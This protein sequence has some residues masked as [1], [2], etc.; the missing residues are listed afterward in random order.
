MFFFLNTSLH[1]LRQYHTYDSIISL[2]RFYIM[3]TK[4]SS[5][6]EHTRGSAIGV[7]IRYI[8]KPRFFR[9]RNIDFKV[10]AHKTSYF[11]IAFEGL[12]VGEIEKF[13][14]LGN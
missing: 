8:M 6:Q 5:L 13:T 12:A 4:Y 3:K 11:V 9:D 1:I 2:Y 10:V 7:L 14:P